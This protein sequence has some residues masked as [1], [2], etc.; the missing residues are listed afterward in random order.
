MFRYALSKSDYCKCFMVK[1]KSPDKSTLKQL[2]VIPLPSPR[3]EELS[4]QDFNGG[5]K[6]NVHKH[7][8]NNVS[9]LSRIFADLI[10][11]IADSAD[12]KTKCPVINTVD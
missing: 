6:V 2:L 12:V 5:L 7:P 4:F 3:S 10:K 11:I 9:L 8:T 1:K